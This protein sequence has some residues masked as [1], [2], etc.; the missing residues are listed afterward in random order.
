[1]AN[2]FACMAHFNMR[3]TFSASQMIDLNVGFNLRTSGLMETLDFSNLLPCFFSAEYGWDSA[4]YVIGSITCAWFIF[5]WYLIFDSPDKHP[6]M[7]PKVST[8]LPSWIAS[9][10]L[11]MAFPGTLETDLFYITFDWI[12]FHR[13]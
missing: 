8:L 11:C 4:F 10:I 7:D 2:S 3:S 6:R 13:N 12:N 5:W 9:S 1:M